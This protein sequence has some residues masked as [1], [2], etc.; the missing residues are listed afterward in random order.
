MKPFVE[1]NGRI[2]VV[3]TV[4]TMRRSLGLIALS[5]LLIQGM[6]C[7]KMYANYNIGS[8]QKKVEQAKVLK[9]EELASDSLTATTKMINSAV[10]KVGTQDFKG[11]VTD[12]KEASRLAKELLART[13]Q[14]RAKQLREQADFWLKK[15]VLNQAQALDSVHLAQYQADYDQGV[16]YFDKES[17]DNA[18]K[19]F[20]AVQTN[21]TFLLKTLLDQAKAGL[22]ETKQLKEDLKKEGAEKYAPEYVKDMENLITQIGKFIDEEK[23]YRQ[24]ISY[25]DKAR[26]TKNEGITATKQVKS[27]EQIAEIESLLNTSRALQAEIYAYQNFM[28]C[29][30]SY[31]AIL[32]DFYNQKYDSVLAMAPNLKPKVDELIIETKREAANAKAKE[33]EKDINQLTDAK[34]RTYLPG[35]VEQLDVY[36]KR[37]REEFD[38]KKYEDSKNDSER[39]LE[40]FQNIQNEFNSL[41]EQEYKRSSDVLAE[42]ENVFRTM[43]D[44]FDTKITTRMDPEDQRLE[45]AKQAMKEELRVKLENAR[46][47]LEMASLKRQ[48]KDFD[49]AIEMVKKVAQSADDVHQQTYRLVAHNAILEIANKLSQLERDGGR[50]YAAAETDKT[51]KML[52]ESK[53]LLHGAKFRE[54]VKQAADTRAQLAVLNQELGR[55]AVKKIDTAQGT[56]ATAKGSRAEQ[57]QPDTFNQAIVSLDRAKAALEGEGLH[58]AIQL[59]ETASKLA[60]DASDKALRQWASEEIQRSDVLLNKARKAGSDR[61]APEKMQKAVDTRATLQTLFDQGAYQQAIQTG[62]QTV[63]AADDAFFAKVNEAEAEIATAKRYGGWEQEPKA[64]ADAMVSAA[65]SR[66]MMEKGTYDLALQHAQGAIVAAKLV[67]K[68]AKRKSFETRMAALQ[69]RLESAKEKGAGFY[70]SKD[71]SKIL[72]EMNRLRNEFDGTTYEDLA[73]GVEKLESQLAGV[74]EMTP[75][76]LTGLVDS[77]QAR[78]TE[79]DKRRAR[80][81]L[82]EKM[83]EVERRIKYAQID[84]KAEKY[85]SSFQNVNFASKQMDAIAQNLDEREF[86]HAISVQLMAFNAVLEKFAPVLNVGSPALIQMSQGTQGRMRSVAIMNASSPSELLTQFKEIDARIRLIVVP[87]SRRDIRAATL[88]MLG[89]AMT[90]AQNFEKLLILD[91]YNNADAKQIIE[92]AFLQMHQSRTQLQ[93]IQ[94]ALKYP[95]AE[96]LQARG[97]ERVV[98][99]QGE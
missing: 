24:A 35:K 78:L 68:D 77:M 71:V 84:F 85:Q 64:L 79:L 49:L 63:A 65:N 51:L 95:Q 31:S 69:K 72:S 34:A 62:E 39:G 40:L 73:S 48:A 3:H 32:N 19:V 92:I 30:K 70:Q 13:K 82:P 44:I 67:A 47:S 57:Y 88:K 97:V 42:S 16:K 46:V 12:S 41:A 59:A 21:V 33:V 98:S 43:Q 11:A 15:A 54:A 56:L 89:L 86:D 10:G 26:Q 58:Q 81:L 76:V 2:V 4:N 7:N 80:A 66:E 90:A 99:N 9:A 27:K 8:A 91:Q 94:H 23:D 53:T 74:M 6:G 14:L 96:L 5:L 17:Y 37:A 75:D 1:D 61:Y 83:D 28:E 25:R 38:A 18:I 52:E 60:G 50:Q 22:D 20:D 55:V 36:L 93:D 87:A 45:D 29:G